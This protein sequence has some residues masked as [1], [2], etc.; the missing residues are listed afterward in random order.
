MKLENIHYVHL[1]LLQVQ[2][3][4]TVITLIKV[5]FKELNS[6]AIFKIHLRLILFSVNYVTSSI[7][8][9]SFSYY[10]QLYVVWPIN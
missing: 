10:Y 6:L 7:K 9:Q 4:Y 2:L 5:L 8:I 3:V 1:A